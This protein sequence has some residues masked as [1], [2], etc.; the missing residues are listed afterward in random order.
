MAAAPGGDFFHVVPDSEDEEDE[1]L[2]IIVVPDSKD[3]EHAM[4]EPV[5]AATMGE[6]AMV[7]PVTAVAMGEAAWSKVMRRL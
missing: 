3:Q 6:V 7:E 1:P 4:V 5:T 2:E